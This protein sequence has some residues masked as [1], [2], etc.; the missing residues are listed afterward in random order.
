M[1]KKRLLASW[2]APLAD[3]INLC[4]LYESSLVVPGPSW[5]MRKTQEIKRDVD[6]TKRS[7]PILLD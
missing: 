2:F 7:F 4:S 6:L 3:Y 5:D 1:F